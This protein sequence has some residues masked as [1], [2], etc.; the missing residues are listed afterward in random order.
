MSEPIIP[1][2]NG[3]ERM[4]WDN[5]NC[6]RCGL[7]PW[8]DEGRHFGRCDIFDALSEAG[9]GDGTVS[10]EIADRMGYPEPRCKAF[11]EVMRMTPTPEE[12]CRLALEAW[13][14]CKAEAGKG[15]P[16]LSCPRQCSTICRDMNHPRSTEYLCDAGHAVEVLGVVVPE[17]TA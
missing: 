12:F 11:V 2:S 5:A 6:C 7:D 10:A 16:C 3:T 8:Q 17:V 14:H 15:Q 9:I 1:F 13:R 4:E